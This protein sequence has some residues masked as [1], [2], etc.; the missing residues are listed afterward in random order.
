MQIKKGNNIKIK[1]CMI[2]HY[3][4][5]YENSLITGKKIK[6]RIK[7]TCIYKPTHQNITAANNNTE[8][9]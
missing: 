6:L 5:K 9:K 3:H 7:A 8:N 2:F 1:L 4:A